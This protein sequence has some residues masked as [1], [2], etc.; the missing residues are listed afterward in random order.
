[1]AKNF[2]IRAVA[3]VAGKTTSAI[4]RR[5]RSLGIKTGRKGFTADQAHSLIYYQPK[6]SR[7]RTES[8]EH[9]TARLLGA[10]QVMHTRNRKTTAVV[11]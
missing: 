5:A 9:E 1:M 8:L 11:S 2:S 7:I 10:L 3:V 4:G 6:T